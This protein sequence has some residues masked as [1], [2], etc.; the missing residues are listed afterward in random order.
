LQDTERK[1]GTRVVPAATHP[2]YPPNCA[3]SFED[4]ASPR[5]PHFFAT[6]SKRSIRF[7]TR[8]HF[9]CSKGWELR[10][11]ASSSAE[12]RFDRLFKEAVMSG[13]ETVGVILTIAVIVML[14]WARYR[15]T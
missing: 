14:V 6:V 12:P 4:C 13:I 5:S 3:V 11:A 2:P 1:A 10:H 7:R 15:L 9:P 8:R